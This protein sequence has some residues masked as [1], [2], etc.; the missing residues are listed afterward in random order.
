MTVKLLLLKSNEDVIA[1]VKEL[2]IEERVIGYQLKN[3]YRVTLNKAEV[4]F[5]QTTTSKKNVGITFFPWMPLSHDKEIPIPSDWLVTMV[6]P[7]KQLK[8]SY[9]DK[10]NDQNANNSIGGQDDSVE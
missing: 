6:E 5:E 2:T 10:M 3:P 7:V 1:D 9:E 8:E 4:L